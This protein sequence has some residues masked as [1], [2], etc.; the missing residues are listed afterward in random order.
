MIW[1][2]FLGPDGMSLPEDQ[3]LLINV[4]L[5]A[6][7]KILMDEMRPEHRD[8]LAP[9][10]RFFCHEGPFRMAEGIVTRLTG[11]FTPRDGATG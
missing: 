4:E 6:R 1:P 10:V 8:R 5:L 3:P 2:D 9:G 7:M 11:L